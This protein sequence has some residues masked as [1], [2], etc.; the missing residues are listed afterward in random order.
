MTHFKEKNNCY[1]CKRQLMLEVRCEL[2]NR[3]MLCSNLLSDE[4]CVRYFTSALL[5]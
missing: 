2:W 4:S 1:S 5:L 3:Q